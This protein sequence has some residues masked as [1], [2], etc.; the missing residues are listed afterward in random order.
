MIPFWKAKN[1]LYHL[2]EGTRKMVNPRGHNKQMYV[3]KPYA[4]SEKHAKK[5]F[6]VVRS[7]CILRPRTRA[8]NVR[9]RLKLRVRRFDLG[10]LLESAHT[11]KERRVP[12]LNTTENIRGT[13]TESRTDYKYFT[14]W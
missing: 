10:V 8:E 2:L 12:A 3:L 11:C 9:S 7:T 6:V 14:N 13:E 4:G 5:R 1:T